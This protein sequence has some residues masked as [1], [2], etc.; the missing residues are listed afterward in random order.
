ML[1]NDGAGKIWEGCGG[2]VYGDGS[3]VDIVAAVRDVI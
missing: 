1:G 3:K 2:C